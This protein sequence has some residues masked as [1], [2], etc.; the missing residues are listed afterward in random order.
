M[1]YIRKEESFSEGFEISGIHM[2][3]QSRLLG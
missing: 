2:P 1:S 3:T